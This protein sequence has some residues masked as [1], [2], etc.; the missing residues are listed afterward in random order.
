MASIFAHTIFLVSVLYNKPSWAHASTW[1][2]ALIL[3]SISLVASIAIYPYEHQ[4]PI[5]S[6]RDGGQT[7]KALIRWAAIKII[8]HVLRIIFLLALVF[9]YAVF[10]TL[11]ATRHYLAE[12]RMNEASV[13]Q[14][15]F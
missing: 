14:L 1:A 6:D 3:E 13:K 7:R 5:S 8:L 11:P 2:L 10:V 9:S 12:K 4:E 15:I